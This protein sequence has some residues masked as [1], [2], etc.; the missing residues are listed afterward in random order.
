[1]PVRIGAVFELKEIVQVY[2]FCIRTL[3]FPVISV[4]INNRSYAVVVQSFP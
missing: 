2:G 4:I 3:H 1:M